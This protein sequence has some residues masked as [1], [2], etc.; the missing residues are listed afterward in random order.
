MWLTKLREWS[1]KGIACAIVTVIDTS[2]S[3]PRGPG[4]KMV[5]NSLGEAAGTIGGGSVEHAAKKEAAKAMGSRRCLLKEYSLESGDTTPEGVGKAMGICGGTLKIFIEP[6][7]PGN[8]VVIFGGGHIGEKLGRMCEALPVPYSVFD[9]RPEYCTPERFP[10]AGERVTADYRAIRASI[11]LG[12]R[13]YCVILTHGHEFDEVCLEQLAGMKELPYIGMIGSPQKV[14]LI[15]KKLKDR[16]IK[17]DGRVYSPVGLKIAFQQPGEIAVAILAEI[18][19][20]MNG[21]KPEHCRI[22]PQEWSEL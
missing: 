1:E 3:T 10:G 17:P 16:N 13:S 18:L 6:V 19:L 5:V 11:N 15:L 22:E 4:S 21:G 8:K 7:I 20:V 12:P 2:G 14:K 9:N